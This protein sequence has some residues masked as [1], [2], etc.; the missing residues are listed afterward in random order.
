MSIQGKRNS[1][2]TYIKARSPHGL[3]RLI[4]QRELKDGVIYDWDIKEVKGE[5]FAF[6]RRTIATTEDV[7][8][9]FD[10]KEAK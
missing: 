3:R 6:Y 10:D 8:K 1:I 4:S 2:L 9:E 5:W 7:L